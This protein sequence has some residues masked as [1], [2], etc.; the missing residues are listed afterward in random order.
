MPGI[1]HFKNWYSIPNDSQEFAFW[2]SSFIITLP[3]SLLRSA[4]LKV[5]S[6]E[7]WSS[8]RPVQ[9]FH[10]HTEVLL[11]RGTSPGYYSRGWGTK[12]HTA[13]LV[14]D[15]PSLACWLFHPPSDTDSP[16]MN[17]KKGRPPPPLAEP[18]NDVMT[19]WDVI[20]SPPWLLHPWVHYKWLPSAYCLV[21]SSHPPI[22]FVHVPTSLAVLPHSSPVLRTIDMQ[23]LPWWFL[24]TQQWCNIY[25]GAVLVTTAEHEF[26]CLKGRIVLGYETF[27]SSQ[28][29]LCSPVFI[30]Q[31]LALF[32][33]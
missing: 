1:S 15:L 33:I 29:F 30:E 22:S 4:F 2:L 21:C 28:S 6:L 3:I 26:C 10:K 17:M 5:C 14:P 23:L 16:F 11:L 9:G 12:T 7:L 13:A 20:I 31:F 32:T 27:Y 8:L 18:R 19:L 25:G 24:L